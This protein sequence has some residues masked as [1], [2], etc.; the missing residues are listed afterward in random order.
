MQA[1]INVPAANDPSQL[2]DFDPGDALCPGKSSLNIMRN[3]FP[4]GI[5]NI[6]SAA[7][8]KQINPTFFGIRLLF[9]IGR[10]ARAL[11]KFII[12]RPERKLI[13]HVLRLDDITGRM[14]W[15]FP[16]FFMQIERNLRGT[17]AFVRDQEKFLLGFTFEL[18]PKSLESKRGTF[19]AAPSIGRVASLNFNDDATQHIAIEGEHAHQYSEPERATAQNS[20]D[21]FRLQTRLPVSDCQYGTTGENER[22]PVR[23]RRFNEGKQ[24]IKREDG[25]P[26]PQYESATGTLTRD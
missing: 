20:P 15:T 25:P 17:I 8:L 26:E 7:S 3:I 9:R 5:L 11:D 24:R 22:S 10:A 14:A 18:N 6:K 16:A 2:I 19:P 13:H 1:N 4:A 21:R 12:T 23:P